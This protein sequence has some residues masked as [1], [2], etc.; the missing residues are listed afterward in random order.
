M[1]STRK[2]K[3]LGLA[4]LVCVLLYFIVTELTSPNDIV[5]NIIGS[6]N[7]EG[8]QEFIGKVDDR[9][10]SSIGSIGD[11]DDDDRINGDDDQPKVPEK[12]PVPSL[13]QAEE[14]LPSRKWCGVENTPQ[15]R[16]KYI[17][18]HKT[19]SSTLTNIFHRYGESNGLNMALPRDNLFYAYARPD[20]PSILRSV[21]HIGNK[22]FPYDIMASGH[23]IYSRDALEQVVPGGAYI[24]ILRHPY[25]HFTS[26]W[27]HWHVYEHIQHNGGPELSP[28]EFLDNIEKYKKFLTRSDEMLLLN[29]MAFDLGLQ[30]PS[31]EG[32]RK[33]IEDMDEHFAVVLITEYMMESLIL[34]KRRLCWS[35]RDVLHVS[36][37]V[38]SQHKEMAV[39]DHPSLKVIDTL[40]FADMMLYEHF[41]QSLWRQIEQEK[42]H[43]GFDEEVAE[44]RDQLKIYTQKCS[45]FKNHDE[46]AHRVELEEN[47]MLTEENRLCHLMMLDSKGFV[48]HL[49]KRDGYD[50]EKLEC[51]AA[52][53]NK[54]MLHLVTDNPADD[55]VSNLFSLNPA[56]T[57]VLA[58]EDTTS[59]GEVIADGLLPRPPKFIHRKSNAEAF[60]IRGLT[61]NRDFMNSFHPN[62]MYLSTFRHPVQEFLDAWT[63]LKVEEM[64]RA[65]DPS[66]DNALD[67]YLDNPQHWHKTL[68]RKGFNLERHLT[69][70]IGYRMGVPLN[71][72]KDEMA[73]AL[74]H[75]WHFTHILI[76]EHPIAS[77]VM[78]RRT[79]CWRLDDVVKVDLDMWNKA[80][81][82]EIASF[83]SRPPNVVEK[84]LLSIND[85]DFELH[86]R[87]RD[88]FHLKTKKQFRARDGSIQKEARCFFEF[89]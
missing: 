14:T 10:A 87:A 85:V 79:M 39:K 40:N 77:L 36:L 84:E 17:K 82:F 2:V 37:K 20:T 74:T 71:P 72:T 58:F 56:L 70:R 51:Y 32:A 23:G 80:T 41:N 9:V 22:N 66:I 57:N 26:S 55:Q 62:M 19:G 7:A 48:K 6:R 18:T 78:L 4:A 16:I 27:S 49:K 76:A 64:M 44:L 12:K 86:R 65:A 8:E 88:V 45:Q 73:Y 42:K 5:D 3:A 30:T 35:I 47:E 68:S 1:L 89:L 83:T 38:S 52:S 13:P 29:N 59:S 50:I 24:T 31:L 81:S 46:D 67:A 11:D 21:E 25:K 61:Y 34:M 43:G 53:Y 75:I 54:K 33:L 28:Y 69:N 60:S 63:R 15:T